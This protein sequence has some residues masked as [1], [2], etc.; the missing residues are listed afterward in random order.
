MEVGTKDWEWSEY[1]K[2]SNRLNDKYHRVISEYTTGS[3]KTICLNDMTIVALAQALV[4]PVI[5]ME[6]RRA[7]SP[8]KKRIPDIC[9]SE[10][11]EHLSFNDFLRRENISV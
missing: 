8:T 5:S 10:G 9:H 1:V 7:N 4:L 2:H 11:T 3:A 6:A